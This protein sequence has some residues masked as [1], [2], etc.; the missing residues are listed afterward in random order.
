[1]GKRKPPPSA[2]RVE[3]AI[4][5]ARKSLDEKLRAI[6]IG[7]KHTAII[8]AAIFAL[9]KGIE[10]GA[11]SDESDLLRRLVIP[12]L[13]K[14]LPTREKLIP[15][16]LRD[17]VIAQTVFEIWQTYGY[18]PQRARDGTATCASSIVADALASPSLRKWTTTLGAD[19]VANIY[20]AYLKPKRGV[21]SKPRKHST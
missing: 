14:M 2:D 12:E 10:G 16:P 6:S 21:H 17:I 15:T 7:S 4:K 8:N 3:E 18:L 5:A 1:M 19:R 9:N 13:Q 11:L 20:L